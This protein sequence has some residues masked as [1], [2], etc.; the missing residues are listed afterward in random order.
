M[1]AIGTALLWF[2]WYGFNAGSELRVDSVTTLAFLNTDLAASFAAITWLIIEWSREKKPKFIGLMTGAVAGL[3]TITPAAGYVPLWAAIIIGILAGSVS[4]VAVQLK[5]RQGWDDA[6]DVWGV[7]GMG[8]VLGTIL[9]GVF[10]TTTVNPHGANGLFFGGGA[11]FMKE[12]IA[13]VLA[14]AYAFLF[15]LLMLKLINYITPVKV[16]REI[17]LLGIDEGEL[18]EKA[19]DEGTL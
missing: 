19:Y 3:A 2:G 18:G 9:L 16:N 8:G 14:A 7:H 11:F 1:V 12:L 4:F 10:A 13:V 6:L 15:T 17:E 5:N